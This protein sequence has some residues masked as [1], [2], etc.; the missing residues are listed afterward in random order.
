MNN[1]ISYRV[2]N[3]LTQDVDILLFTSEGDPNNQA[4]TKTKY[5][6]DLSAETIF[7]TTIVQISARAVNN[8]TFELYTVY[9]P[10]GEITSLE[11]VV[12]LLNTLN[13]GFFN[14]ESD[15]VTIFNLNDSIV[16]GAIETIFEDDYI[17]NNFVIEAYNYLDPLALTN[18][19][20]FI[21]DYTG[22]INFAMF[23]QFGFL[24]SIRAFGWGA[25]YLLN[26][27]ASSSV[28]KLEGISLVSVQDNGGAFLI[29]D[30]TNDFKNFA[31][32]LDVGTQATLMLSITSV[33]SGE[34]GEAIPFFSSNNS[35]YIYNLSG[36][37]YVQLQ[38]AEF[39]SSTYM[40]SLAGGAFGSSFT[41]LPIGYGDKFPN[42]SKVVGNGFFSGN[43]LSTSAEIP[44]SPMTIAFGNWNG[45]AF[46]VNV[47]SS[48]LNQI[49]NVDW[50]SLTGG[51][52]EGKNIALSLI[53][54]NDTATT[55]SMFMTSDFNTVFN[56]IDLL[57]KNTQD[58]LTI[59][60]T[61]GD[62]FLG[63]ADY[64]T[65]LTLPFRLI[66]FN[67]LDVLLL[68]KLGRLGGY[69]NGG[70][71]Y[72]MNLNLNFN[73]IT[74]QP[75]SFWS[76]TF[77]KLGESA[78]EFTPNN[79]IGNINGSSVGFSSANA[80]TGKGKIGYDRLFNKGLTINTPFPASTQTNFSA[81]VSSVGVRTLKLTITSVFDDSEWVLEG[82][83]VGA[84][85]TQL[86]PFD[87]SN[88]YSMTGGSYS[89]D[90]INFNLINATASIGIILINDLSNEKIITSFITASVGSLENLQITDFT[91]A[92]ED[93]FDLRNAIFSTNVSYEMAFFNFEETKKNAIKFAFTESVVAGYEGLAKFVLTGGDFLWDE[94]VPNTY[95][96]NSNGE[97][98]SCMGLGSYLASA[99]FSVLEGSI[100]V[101]EVN[102]PKLK[103]STFLGVSLQ[104]SQCTFKL[105][106]NNLIPISIG[107]EFGGFTI[108]NTSSTA[109]KI[110]ISDNNFTSFTNDSIQ[111]IDCFSNNREL[112]LLNNLGVNYIGVPRDGLLVVNVNNNAGEYQIQGNPNLEEVFYPNGAL[113]NPPII[114]SNNPLVT[115]FTFALNNTNVNDA[116]SLLIEF[117]S[118]N[119][120][121]G[122]I[123]FVNLGAGG[124]TP[125]LGV[126]GSA[127]DSLISRGW[128]ILSNVPA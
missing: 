44:Q 86:Q 72:N 79:V 28:Q 41:L 3:N 19:A 10:D 89:E 109:N 64:D 66:Q 8:P 15:G 61:N 40:T 13:F 101:P 117:E 11:T 20:T 122:R 104:L 85:D 58:N 42:I 5:S 25:C 38:Q 84:T 63:F 29:T 43:S 116:N 56:T 1:E 35:D 108:D 69:I 90:E 48:V 53:N 114:F 92:N 9:N 98:I 128:T 4:N 119:T 27:G 112:I 82:N 94:V 50:A 70:N 30:Y 91:I 37:A 59:N 55:H 71:D 127:Y 121:N 80:I 12:A 88:T 99:N 21:T 95:Y 111:L 83:S 49:I 113:Q 60:N 39:L 120:Y 118:Y 76:S 31:N 2:K 67:G 103:A 126:S 73:N 74:S 22:V 26:S 78:Y 36:L 47:G 87:T 75:F 105:P 125:T 115:R 16:F 65:P 96:E 102:A 107:G 18:Q 52:I 100:N 33:L 45:D 68:P 6:W 23:N 17:L 124:V 81:I 7:N 93:F 34:N 32:P 97:K 106:E 123:D 62:V 77:A 57:T 14:L 110:N 51:F 24:A 46:T 54:R